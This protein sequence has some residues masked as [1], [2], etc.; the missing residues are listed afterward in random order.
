MY[1]IK[2]ILFISL[3]TCSFSFSDDVV[4]ENQEILNHDWK[5]NVFS[6][7]NGMLPLG[8]FENGRPLKAMSL[9]A[10]KHYW[11]IE[12]NE[13]KKNSNVSDRNRSFWWLF[14]LNLYGIVEAYVDYHLKDFPKDEYNNKEN[15]ESK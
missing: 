10:M 7:G 14:V 5:L 8:Q 12:Y 3:V 2:N 4:L 9:I 11:L 6:L 15:L 1:K 13:A